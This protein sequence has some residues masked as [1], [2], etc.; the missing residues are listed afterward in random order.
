MHSLSNKPQSLMAEKVSVK[1]C[2]FLPAPF[3][4]NPTGQHDNPRLIQSICTK[5]RG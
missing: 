5:S 4:E 2:D 3:Y 1:S